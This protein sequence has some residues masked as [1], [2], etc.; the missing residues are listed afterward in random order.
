MSYQ[1]PRNGFR[2]FVIAALGAFQALFCVAQL[3]NPSLLRV[4]DKEHLDR[5]A[6]R[7]AGEAV[8]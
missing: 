4:D 7:A 3:F 1:A 2:T 5:M 6:A 8:P